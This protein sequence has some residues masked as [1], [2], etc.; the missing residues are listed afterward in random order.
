MKAERARIIAFFILK[1]GM[2]RVEVWRVG[3]R[4]IGVDID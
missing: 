3:L 2:E 4:K 1:V